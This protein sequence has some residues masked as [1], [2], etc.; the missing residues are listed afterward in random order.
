MTLYHIYCRGELISEVEA[1]DELHAR[2]KFI[3]DHP[4]V[5]ILMNVRAS[6]LIVEPAP[7][8]ALNDELA[9]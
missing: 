4:R 8:V 7:W 3:E 2:I 5:C 1:K 9:C 6:E